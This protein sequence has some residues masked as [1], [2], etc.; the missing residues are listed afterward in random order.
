MLEFFTC[1]AL[2]VAIHV[3]VFAAVKVA[4]ELAKRCQPETA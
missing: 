1:L 3:I 4:F 2:L